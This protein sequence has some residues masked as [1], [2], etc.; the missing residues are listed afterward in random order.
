MSDERDRRLSANEAIAREE[1]EGRELWLESSASGR[2]SFQCE[3]SDADCSALVSLDSDE[4][5]AVRRNDRHFLVAP[6]HFDP[7]I[8]K[9][10]ERYDS[11]WVLEKTTPGGIEV[12]EERAHP[13]RP[14]G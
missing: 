7:S 3:C 1:N 5:R 10:V 2:V 14:V 9:V 13:G 12:V 11:Y 4:Y 8:G 6:G